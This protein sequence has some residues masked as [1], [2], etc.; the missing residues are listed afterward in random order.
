[1]CHPLQAQGRY[2]VLPGITKPWAVQLV[3][4]QLNVPI[5]LLALGKCSPDGLTLPSAAKGCGSLDCISSRQVL[6]RLVQCLLPVDRVLL[7]ED[8]AFWWTDIANAGAANINVSSSWAL[9]RLSS[10]GCTPEDASPALQ[11]R[12]HPKIIINNI[13]EAVLITVATRW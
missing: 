4:E 6:I 13:A 1:M 11:P 5:V 8:W 2:L 10:L 12:L 3:S 9:Y 7:Q